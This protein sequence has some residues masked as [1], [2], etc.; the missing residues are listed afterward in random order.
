MHIY[1]SKILFPYM[2]LQNI[3]YSFLFYTV[4]PFWLPILY[5]AVCIC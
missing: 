1:L 3:V 5:I 2:L 4:G